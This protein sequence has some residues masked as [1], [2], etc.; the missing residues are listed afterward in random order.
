VEVLCDEDV[1]SHIGPESC[2]AAREDRD[3]A[4]TGER[5]GQPLS[6]ETF[7]IQDADV[8]AYDGRQNERVRYGECPNGPA[9]SQT[10]ACTDAPCA[11]TGRSPVRP[12]AP[13][14]GPHREG[15]E[16]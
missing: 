1:A 3:E 4:L 14:G 6:R 9:W 15:E 8:V 10:L 2:G 16:P 12:F 13:R 11:G 7:L 5:A